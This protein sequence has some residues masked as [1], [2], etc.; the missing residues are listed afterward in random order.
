MSSEL[1]PILIT[2]GAGFIGSHLVRQWLAEEASPVVNLDKLTYA[3]HLSSLG[4]ALQDARH[5]F[6]SGDIADLN[7]LPSLFAQHRPRG[8]IH[9]AAETH[10][11]RSIDRPA[12]FFETNVQ[13]TFALLEATLQYWQTLNLAERDAFRFLHVSTDEV[14]G[15][16]GERERFDESSPYAPNSPYAASKA[17][18]DHF[19]RAYHRTY[20]LPTIVTNS[21]NNYGSHQSP[22]KFIPL[23][24]C[25]AMAGRAVPIYGDGLQQRD[26]LHVEDHCTALRLVLARGKVGETYLVGSGE[27]PTNLEL[28]KRICNLVDELRPGLPHAPST[29]LLTHVPDRP[30]HDRRYA[31]DA[32]KLRRE[33]AW[34]PTFD[35]HTALRETVRWYLEHPEWIAEASA[36][37]PQLRVGIS[38][39]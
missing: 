19:V 30:G 28:A 11:D 27:Q 39:A 17:A 4:S 10:V 1:A 12:V 15:A 13:G 31:L 35:F 6:V 38:P 24:I 34:Q 8:V 26:W 37:L 16:A 20:G 29:S 3:G 18:A 32:S 7:L 22:E 9:L 23:V 33:L 2:G 36:Q 21:S 14:F 25:R 5:R